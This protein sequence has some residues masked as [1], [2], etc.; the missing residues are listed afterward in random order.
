MKNALIAAGAVAVALSGCASSGPTTQ[1]SIGYEYHTELAQLLDI[2]MSQQD[3]K[4][5]LGLAYD[6]AWAE[7]VE[8]GVDVWPV[9]K[10]INWHATIECTPFPRQGHGLA[11]VYVVPTL[12]V[13]ENGA[14]VSVDSPLAYA[15]SR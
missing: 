10:A 5:T 13:F 15:Y 6:P 7:E 9:C 4:D 3:V 14:L 2:G 12:L 11:A 1:R 8:P